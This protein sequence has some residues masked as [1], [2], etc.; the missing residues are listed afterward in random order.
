MENQKVMYIES[1]HAKCYRISQMD[2]AYIAE[3]EL[4]VVNED[5]SSEQLFIVAEEVASVG[6]RDACIAACS[7]IEVMDEW[8]ESNEEEDLGTITE[9]E[10][11]D[12]AIENS[13]YTLFFQIVNRMLDELTGNFG[14]EDDDDDEEDDE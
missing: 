14:F 9:Y 4:K 6:D 8:D 12:D 3:V 10:D 2:E 11:I 7:R 1:E 5:G 13:E